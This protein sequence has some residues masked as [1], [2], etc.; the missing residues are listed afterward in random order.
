MY[1]TIVVEAVLLV[2]FAVL[3]VGVPGIVYLISSSLYLDARLKRTAP[4]ESF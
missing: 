4:K 2:P 3:V 1:F